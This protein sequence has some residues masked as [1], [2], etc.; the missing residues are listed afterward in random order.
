MAV[1]IF[2]TVCI[3]HYPVS[4]AGVTCAKVVNECESNPCEPGGICEDQV[5]GFLCHYPP[6][7]NGITGKLLKS[8]PVVVHPDRATCNFLQ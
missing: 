3:F 7:N 6:G 1:V 4:F 8:M 2:V 5:N